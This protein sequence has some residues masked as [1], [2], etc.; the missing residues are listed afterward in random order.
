ME[1]VELK[2]FNFSVKEKINWF[3]TLNARM[4][5]CRMDYLMLPCHKICPTKLEAHHSDLSKCKKLIIQL[6]KT[7]SLHRDHSLVVEH[8]T[9]DPENPGSILGRR[10]VNILIF[11]LCFL[12]FASNLTVILISLSLLFSLYFRNKN[13]SCF[14][15]IICC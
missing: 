14:S 8:L 7:F 4:F 5:P 2:I 6:S 9:C 11:L 10:T 1:L 12:S 3:I 13:P 15:I